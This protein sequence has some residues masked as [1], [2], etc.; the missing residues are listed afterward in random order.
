MRKTI[1]FL[2]R[3]MP[4]NCTLQYFG[5]DFNLGSHVFKITGH[6]SDGSE[7]FADVIVDR[8][9]ALISRIPF[10]DVLI[11][12]DELRDQVNAYEAKI[13]A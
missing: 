10:V 3:E 4:D 13:N 1:E 8:E 6:C 12:A 9:L 5:L 11:C 2:Y 7:I